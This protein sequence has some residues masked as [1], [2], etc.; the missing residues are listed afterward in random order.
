MFA[1]NSVRN[2]GAERLFDAIAEI[3]YK[4]TFQYIALEENEITD[5]EFIRIIAEIAKLREGSLSSKT[6]GGYS[7]KSVDNSA[8]FSSKSETSAADLSSQSQGAPKVGKLATRTLA[9]STKTEQPTPVQ[10]T[11]FR[12]TANS[13]DNAAAP[14]EEIFEALTMKEKIRRAEAASRAPA[15]TGPQE[16]F[17]AGG[18]PKKET[19]APPRAPLFGTSKPTTEAAKGPKLDLKELTSAISGR[20]PEATPPDS[21]ATKPTTSTLL[22]NLNVFGIGGTKR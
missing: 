3:E 12:S 17:V 21:K 10:T 11:V 15:T 19:I 6:Q 22:N 14:V 4:E 1:R 8:T 7:E 16:K 13:S 2:K 20:A 5:P 18:A 9:A